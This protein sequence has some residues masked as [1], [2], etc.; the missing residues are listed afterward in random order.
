MIFLIVCV[1]F[2]LLTRVQ[3]NLPCIKYLICHSKSE[4]QK[5]PS[6]DGITLG[7][8]RFVYLHVET[9]D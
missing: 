4:A 6:G 1:S 5:F 2:V 8:R 3:E 7:C 9:A